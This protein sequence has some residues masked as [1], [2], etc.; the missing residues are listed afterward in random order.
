MSKADVVR[1][2]RAASADVRVGP[3]PVDTVVRQGQQRVRR[4]RT[5]TIGG[6]VALVGALLMTG[7]IVIRQD[8][9][10]APVGPVERDNPLPLPWWGDDTLHLTHIELPVS[11]PTEVVALYD[12]AAYGTEAGQV[13]VVNAEGDRTTVGSKVPG[14]PM[15]AGDAERWL[16]WVDPGDQAPELVVYDL[17]QE[18]EVG[19]LALP[20]RGP[21][22]GRLD[23]GSYPISIDHGRVYYA[24]QNGDWSWTPDTPDPQRETSV[25]TDMVDRRAGVEITRTWSP[26]QGWSHRLRVTPATNDVFSDYRGEDARLSPGGTYVAVSTGDRTKLFRVGSGS[27]LD[28][29][30]SRTSERSILG[31]AFADDKT[32]VLVSGGRPAPSPSPPVSGFIP[33]TTTMFDTWDVTTCDLDTGACRTHQDF[34]TETAPMLAGD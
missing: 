10:I 22:W 21:R 20:Y 31:V 17:A 23:D 27:S 18:A 14:A 6:T 1:A 11:Q 24:T 19:R 13:V 29:D 7:S 5:T 12:G 16:A 34:T 4:R 15:A 2:I 3:P 9:S 28:L 26:G 33:N 25:N 8:S 32:V 30:L